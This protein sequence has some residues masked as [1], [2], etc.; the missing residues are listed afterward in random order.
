[1]HFF[2]I[3]Q[4]LSRLKLILNRVF[5]L[6]SSLLEYFIDILSISLFKRGVSGPLKMVFA[7]FANPLALKKAFVRFAIL[8]GCLCVITAKTSESF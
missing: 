4:I 1:M 2:A 3:S 8:R 7:D 6:L 5:N